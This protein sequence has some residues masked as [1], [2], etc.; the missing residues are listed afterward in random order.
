MALIADTPSCRMHQLA[1]RPLRTTMIAHARFTVATAL[2]TNRLSAHTIAWS[3]LLLDGYPNSS[4]A[5]GA[6]RR[7]F[8]HHHPL[9]TVLLLCI[10]NQSASLENASGTRMSRCHPPRRRYRHAAMRSD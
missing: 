6:P 2:G 5:N 1:E 9:S 10:R 4:R 8:D 7:G 3:T